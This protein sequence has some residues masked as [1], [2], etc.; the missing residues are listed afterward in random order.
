[1]GRKSSIDTLSP[2]V[3][4]WLEKSL[5]EG[6][7]TGYQALEE[8]LREMGYAISKSAIHRYGSKLERRLSSIKASTE[9]ARVICQ[10]AGDE[11][12]DRSEALIA[13]VQSELFEAIV[14][15]KEAS[16]SDDQAERIGIL[17]EAAK[18]I[19]NL[20]RASFNLKRYQAEVRAKLDAKLAA[21][22]KESDSGKG[23]AFDKETLRIVR[24]EI[25]GIVG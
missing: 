8:A 24:E 21:L 11:R 13:L 17:L 10:T 14:N 3:R 1:M 25:Y 4:Q 7:F 9:A 19:A 22:E 18:N 2:E 16:E 6:N 12:D 15:L 5:A 23:R 20:T